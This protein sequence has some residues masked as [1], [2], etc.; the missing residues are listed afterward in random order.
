[1]LPD[2]VDP[3]RWLALG[4]LA[5]L[6]STAAADECIRMNVKVMKDASA[7][8]FIGTVVAVEPETSSYEPRTP[9]VRVTFDV[10]R[11]LK[12][13]TTTGVVL[14]QW[15]DPNGITGFENKFSIGGLH[16]VFA[17]DNRDNR[18]GRGAPG[19][20]T[21]PCGFNDMLNAETERR[22]LANVRNPHFVP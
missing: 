15:A 4:V 12:G 14:Q 9:T 11:M 8:A 19:A 21:S 2:M 5:L 22:F 17:I 16:Y 13:H 10:R 18:L 7:V 6:P 1:M 3:R 20:L